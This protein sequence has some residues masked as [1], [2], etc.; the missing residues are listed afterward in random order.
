MSRSFVIKSAIVLVVLVL[1]H[2]VFW[3]FKAGQ[4]EKQVNN[5]ISEN[6]SHISTGEPVAVSGFPLSQKVT[7]K[8][9]KFSIPGPSISKYQTTVKHLE[10]HAGIFSGN[11]TIVLLDQTTVQ[12]AESNISGVV[13]FA[14]DPEISLV[15]AEGA[16]SKFL[17]QDGGF[18]VVDAEKN[19]IYSASST[20]FSFESVAEEGKVKNKIT[21][22]IKDM[23][24]FDVLSVYKNYSEKKIIDGIKTGE[25]SVGSASATSSDLAAAVA[26]GALSPNA[27]PA[28][29][30]AAVE[31]VAA[32]AAP[33]PVAAETADTMKTADMKDG[34]VVADATHSALAAE[35]K[36][37][38]K[39]APTPAIP[40]D[41]NKSNFALDIEYEL[42]PNSNEQQSA[43]AP[44]DPTQ[45]QEVPAQYSK[46]IKLNNIELS[47]SL[48]KI[49]L[50]GQMSTFQDDAMP[51]GSVTVKVE[52][53]DNLITHISEGFSKML[54]QKKPEVVAVNDVQPAV[55]PASADAVV[56]TV[57]PT[58]AAV[59]PA[60]AAAVVDAVKV[61][62]P[63]QNFLKRVIANLSAVSKE[64]SQKNQL[65]QGD[66]AAFDVRREKNIEFLINE[67][68]VRE[69][70]G[71]F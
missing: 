30:A 33:T 47:N 37:D 52:K 48:Y 62:D 29:P 63:Y 69:I 10:A 16:I 4:L 67:T 65:S 54:D 5:F 66:V 12:D 68:P 34:K 21:A 19:M 71:K 58:P 26:P 31:A 9:L 51:S 6:S 1:V 55:A 23:E 41:N 64:L 40:N 28:T 2:S 57:S 7:I 8:D 15:V 60:D 3:F 22:N 53:V 49:S 20:M 70:L 56:A 59:V 46:V 27:A 25:I 17:Y 24:G 61:E 43:Q 11:F 38:S 32:D 45:I 18:K 36:G 14:K 35:A 50:N 39:S 42:V 44:T 13:E